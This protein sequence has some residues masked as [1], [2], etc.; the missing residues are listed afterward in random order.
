[1]LLLC[2]SHALAFVVVFVRNLPIYRL[3]CIPP[4]TVSFRPPISELETLLASRSTCDWVKISE[5][6]LGPVN[7]N[8]SFTPKH[9]SEAY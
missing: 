5:M 3:A 8:F 6:F 1:V 7:E 9:R 2:C 4:H